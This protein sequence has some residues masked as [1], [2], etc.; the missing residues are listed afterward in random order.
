MSLAHLLMLTCLVWPG[1]AASLGLSVGYS[2][3]LADAARRSRELRKS[4]IHEKM[5]LAEIRWRKRCLE[6]RLRIQRG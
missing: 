4:L 6:E 3:R 5:V 2:A 1:L